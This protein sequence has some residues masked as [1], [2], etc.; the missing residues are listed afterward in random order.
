MQNRIPVDETFAPINQTLF[1]QLNKD[2][3]H[4]DRQVFIH[5]EALAAPIQRRPHTSQLL[6][7]GPS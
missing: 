6:R 3:P 4:R 2:F 1:I 7:D 5:G